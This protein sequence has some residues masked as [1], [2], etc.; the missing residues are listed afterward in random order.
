M[1]ELLIRDR[2]MEF[3]PT[4]LTST[5]K[6]T[7]LEQTPTSDSCNA[8]QLLGVL[9]DESQQLSRHSALQLLAD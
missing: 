6:R 1:P 2:E 7:T 5:S 4:F 3:S 9:S 8:S